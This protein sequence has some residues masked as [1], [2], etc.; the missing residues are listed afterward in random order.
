MMS[1]VTLEREFAAGDGEL[2]VLDAT[3]HTRLI[4]SPGNRAEVDAAKATFDSLRA[5]GYLAYRV[6]P[7]G[8]EGEAMTA[9]DPAAEKMILSP[10]VVGG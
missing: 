2:C 5:K 7:D 6:K 4:W 10:P 8:T 3:G 9:F 1:T